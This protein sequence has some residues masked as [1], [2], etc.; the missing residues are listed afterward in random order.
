MFAFK[1]SLKKRI[2]FSENIWRGWTQDTRHKRV[3]SDRKKGDGFNL[4]GG[5]G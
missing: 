2:F 4:R 5:L 3:D 1:D